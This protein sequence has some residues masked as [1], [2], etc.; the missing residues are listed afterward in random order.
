MRERLELESKWRSRWLAEP[1]NTADLSTATAS[2]KF[3]NLVEFPY[4][5]AEGLHVGHVYTYCG[6]DVVGRYARMT[7]RRVFQPIGF[8]SFGI[9][10]EAYALRLGENPDT[11]TRRNIPR[12]RRQLETMGVAWNWEA[13]LTTSDPAYYRWIQWIFVKL[14]R[15]GL[16]V[17]REAEVIRCPSCLTVLAFEQVRAG[18]ANGAVPR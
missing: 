16:A 13:T 8:D 9:Q 6:A 10:T 12:C 1:P 17:Q 3:Y 5:S 4:P 18:G 14:Y 7:G 15:A 11:L 2:Q